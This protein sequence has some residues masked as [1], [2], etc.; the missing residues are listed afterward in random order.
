MES[1]AE[2]AGCIYKLYNSETDIEESRKQIMHGLTV[3][4]TLQI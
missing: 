1:L 2:G 3:R 4:S